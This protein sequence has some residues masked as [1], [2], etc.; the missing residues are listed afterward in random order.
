MPELPEVEIIKRGLEKF[1]LNKRIS[2]VE[3]LSPRVI[4]EPAVKVF[5]SGLEGRVI[6]EILRKAKLLVLKIDNSWYL[7]IH[8]RISGWLGYGSP[9][10]KARVRFIFSEGGCLNYM[11]NRLLGELRLRPEFESLPFLQKLGPEPFD[12][13]IE[14]FKQIL[15]T[16][17]VKIKALI[18]DQGVISGI[19]NIYATEALF[20]AGIS[21]LRPAQSLTGRE[22]AKLYKSIIALLK[23]GIKYRGASVDTYRD[24]QGNKGGM[25]KRLKVYGRQ[26]LGCF[27]CGTILKKI[28]LA[29]R[30][31]VFCPKCQ[32]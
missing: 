30:G 6:T 24:L 25:D 11:D 10:K 27:V 31:T 5:I 1:V 28:T 18:M 20:R 2:R 4:K 16:K 17:K 9:D 29:G 26:G 15:K 21:P 32:K 7:I 8:L 14:E 13:S 22:A 19:G 3:V 23:E 12:L